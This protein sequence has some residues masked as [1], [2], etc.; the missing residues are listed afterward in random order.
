MVILNHLV[1]KI[2]Q[3]PQ[4]LKGGMEELAHALR[5][6]HKVSA[7][8]MDLHCVDLFEHYL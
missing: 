2:R 3:H 6:C 7:G 1:S 5:I 4:F 8:S